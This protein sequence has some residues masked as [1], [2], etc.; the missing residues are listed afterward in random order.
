MAADREKIVARVI[1]GNVAVDATME[2]VH[3][4]SSSITEYLVE[5]GGSLS[6]NRRKNPDK[7]RLTVVITDHPID[8]PASHAD[9]V[10]MAARTV[11]YRQKK[12][13]T[14]SPFG[15]NLT[16]PGPLNLLTNEQ[17][18]KQLTTTAASA[19]L[20]RV[21]AVYDE[22]QRMHD[23]GDVFDVIT[24]YRVFAQMGIESLSVPRVAEAAI[25]FTLDLKAV[26]YA[27]AR[28]IAMVFSS[29][30]AAQKKTSKG[31]QT[32]KVVTDE[33]RKSALARIADDGAAAVTNLL[34]GG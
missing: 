9:G 28:R 6:D 25:E 20:T 12:D 31:K 29:L 2:E 30:P 24:A 21:Q 22:F 5:T 13:I 3:T 15:I 10:V 1:V 33:K 11:T 32:P 18:E 34:G 23:E 17:E 27:T 7:L 8:E 16:V 26:R 14:V 19:P 4:Y